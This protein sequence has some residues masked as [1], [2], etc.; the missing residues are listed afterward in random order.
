ML[1]YYYHILTYY[2]LF[3]FKTFFGLRLGLMTW[4]WRTWT[5]TWA[6]TSDLDLVDLASD[7][8]LEFVDLD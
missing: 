6:W 5:W 4:A 8:G 2:L 1:K 3:I 7:S